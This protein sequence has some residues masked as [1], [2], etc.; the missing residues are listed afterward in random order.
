V[1]RGVGRVLLQALR[2]APGARFEQTVE[3]PLLAGIVVEGSA[4]VG[5]EILGAWDFFYAPA[6][7]R[8]GAIDFPAGATLLTV[9]LQ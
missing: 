4:F 9:T 1:D 8:H 7:A 5:G 6:G 2:F 3:R